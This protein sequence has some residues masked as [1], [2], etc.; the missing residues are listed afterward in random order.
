MM[1]NI[2][3]YTNQ[4]VLVK[5][6][7]IREKKLRFITPV[8]FGHEDEDA[9]FKALFYDC[10][11]EYDFYDKFKKDFV[12]KETRIHILH[13]SSTSEFK[14][15]QEGQKK[16]ALAT[17]EPYLRS[18]VWSKYYAIEKKFAW[19]KYNYAI[20]AHKSQGSTYNNV[21]MLNWDMDKNSKI[22]ERNR[23]KYVAATR[24]RHM[25]YIVK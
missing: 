13:E 19:M 3:L 4:E 7:D 17:K 18:K 6:Y 20:T 1:G 9:E 5:D 25:L 22:E 14:Q 12:K 11:V 8:T 24:P 10:R 16:R 23:I 15:Y 21:M 2:L